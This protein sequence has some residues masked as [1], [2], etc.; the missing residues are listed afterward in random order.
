VWFPIA[1]W[2]DTEVFAYLDSISQRGGQYNAECGAKG[3]ECAGCPAYWSEKRA[4]YLR[5]HYPHFAADYAKDL[6]A[7]R[8]EIAKPLAA[9]PTNAQRPFG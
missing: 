4:A 8:A 6:R 2:S 5:R 1:D 3:P 9:R 7:L